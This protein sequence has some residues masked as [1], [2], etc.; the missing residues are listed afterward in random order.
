M[1]N[2]DSKLLTREQILEVQDI[3][4]EV[5]DVPEWGGS[6]KVQG[7]TGEERD[8]LESSLIRGK[9]KNASI[10]MQNLRAKLVAASVVN[11]NGERV[12]T[13]QDAIALGKKSASALDRVFAVAQEL[14]GITKEDIEE[15]EK[16]L[17]DDRGDGF[18]LG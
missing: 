3:Q 14:S 12:F 8:A 6:V 17:Q 7:L 11:G 10:N 9:G 16:N 2:N 18:G 13:D 15:L 1:G 5:V 4:T